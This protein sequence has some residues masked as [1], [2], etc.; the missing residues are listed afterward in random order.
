L[1]LIASTLAG[2]SISIHIWGENATFRW[3]ATH[4]A[5]ACLQKC[6]CGTRP[7]LRAAERTVGSSKD[8]GKGF[9]RGDDR[10]SSLTARETGQAQKMPVFGDFRGCNALRLNSRRRPFESEF[11]EAGLKGASMCRS[12]R[13]SDSN[14]R[15]DWRAQPH[16]WEPVTPRKVD[17]GCHHVVCRLICVFGRPYFS[18][19]LGLLRFCA[20]LR[21][22]N[23]ESVST[24]FVASYLDE[25]ARS[26]SASTSTIGDSF[27][28]PV[29]ASIGA[30]SPPAA[31]VLL[32][33]PSHT[34]SRFGPP[35]IAATAVGHWT[36]FFHRHE[37]SG[38]RVVRSD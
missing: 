15:R 20:L 30:I 2:H 28:M 8:D 29:V 36:G 6:E 32:N 34:S 25:R 7:I 27:V 14:V 35:L 9:E 16:A 33:P 12:T 37:R 23:G 21:R 31:E 1:Q 17:R 38:L 18:F 5:S 11:P 4:L 13:H 19:D 26:R 3:R 24:N 22:G 10:L